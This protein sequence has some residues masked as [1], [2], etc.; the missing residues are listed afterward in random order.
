MTLCFHVAFHVAVCGEGWGP[1]GDAPQV[2][3]CENKLA[4]FRVLKGAEWVGVGG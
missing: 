3:G 4:C 2:S 1:R